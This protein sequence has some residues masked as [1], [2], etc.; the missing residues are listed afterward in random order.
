MSLRRGALGVSRASGNV[1]ALLLQRLP[2]RYWRR[3]F[4]GLHGA[5]GVL[6]TIE[7]TA[8]GFRNHRG[9]WQQGDAQLLPNLRLIGNER[10][11]RNAV[12]RRSRR[13][14]PR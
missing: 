3:F 4:G 13:G 5:E 8:Q 1:G 7:G 14:E 9:Q 2:A 11:Q 6:Q 12:H 10:L